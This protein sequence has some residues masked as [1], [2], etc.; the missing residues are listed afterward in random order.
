MKK[1]GKIKN[2]VLQE[3]HYNVGLDIGT[4]SVGYAVVDADTGKVLVFKKEKY[5]RWQIV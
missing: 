2:S 3:T 4:S 1:T 5:A